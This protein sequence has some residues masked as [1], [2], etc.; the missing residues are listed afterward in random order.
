VIFWHG[1]LAWL[2]F[3]STFGAIVAILINGWLLFREHPW[4]IPAWHSFREKSANKLFKLG[5]MFFVLQ[6]AFAIGYSSDNIVIAQI[7]GPASVAT[8][9]V[10]Q[11]L[12]G[13]VTMILSMVL[14]SL[15]PAYGEAIVRGDVAWVRRVFFNSLWFTL[16]TTV[17]LC[18]LLVLAGP[19]IL[20]VLF[21][22]ALHAPIS[23]LI[24]LAVWVVV[25]GLSGVSV[26]LL[27]GAGILKVQTIAAV[28]ASVSNLALSILL[29][30]RLG[31]MGVCLGSIVTQVLITLPICFI[32]IR[33]LFRRLATTKM[34]NGPAEATS[35]A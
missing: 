10:P 2:V 30:R 23:L 34:E 7:L 21:G 11:K 19:W 6:C 12:F 1:S 20:R 33:T 4:L 14:T 29:T 31:V 5:L 13:S 22:K 24:V 32:L 15:W 17:P 18:T 25:N 27:N 16:A 35:P 8:Y 3:A 26:T 28:F 9:S